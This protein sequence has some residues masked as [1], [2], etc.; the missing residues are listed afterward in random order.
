MTFYGLGEVFESDYAD[1]CADTCPL[2]SIGGWVEGL[3][4]ADP[5]VRTP[6]FASGNSQTFHEPPFPQHFT[7][8]GLTEDRNFKSSPIVMIF[9]VWLQRVG[10]DFLKVTMQTQVPKKMR[11]WAEGQ[12]CTDLGVMTPIGASGIFQALFCQIRKICSFLLSESGVCIL[13]VSCLEGGG[14]KFVL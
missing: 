4:C 3:A 14:I 6:I 9:W 2:V 13:Q 5:G 12:A 8:F 11:G 1:K 7:V 10:G